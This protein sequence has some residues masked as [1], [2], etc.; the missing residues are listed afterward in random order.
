MLAGSESLSEVTLI[1]GLT[2]VWVLRHC[3]MLFQSLSIF[4]SGEEWKGTGWHT[5]Q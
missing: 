2:C 5:V 3:F 1:H 4:S